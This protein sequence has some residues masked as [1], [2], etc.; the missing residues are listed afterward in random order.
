MSTGTV[1]VHSWNDSTFIPNRSPDS[2]LLAKQ[3]AV[4]AMNGHWL[5]TDD[6]GA[7]E[8][9]LS[10]NA[11]LEPRPSH[12]SSKGWAGVGTPRG[13]GRSS[14]R[15]LRSNPVRAMRYGMDDDEDDGPGW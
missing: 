10:Y 4:G 15:G 14:G 13:W 8:M 12:R 6:D 9:G 1:S 7:P 3:R 5:D 11:K 2:E